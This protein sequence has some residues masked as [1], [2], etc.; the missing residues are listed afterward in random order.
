VKA[1]PGHHPNVTHL[2]QRPPE[3]NETTRKIET[4]EESTS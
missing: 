1:E 2:G 3:T 4:A